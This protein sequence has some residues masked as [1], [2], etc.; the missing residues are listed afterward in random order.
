MDQGIKRDLEKLPRE[1]KTSPLYKRLANDAPRHYCFIH[2]GKKKPFEE[3]TLEKD[4]GVPGVKSLYNK[5]WTKWL[6][7]D[8]PFDGSAVRE[9]LTT[10]R[11][12]YE[13]NDKGKLEGIGVCVLVNGVQVRLARKEFNEYFECTSE[14]PEHLMEIDEVVEMIEPL[15]GFGGVMRKVV[16]KPGPSQRYVSSFNQYNP[17]A[18]VVCE[19]LFN[20][21][22][23]TNVVKYITRNMQALVYGVIKEEVFVD[24]GYHVAKNLMDWCRDKGRISKLIHP[25]LITLFCLRAQE[26]VASFKPEW[27]FYFGVQG[28]EGGDRLRAWVEEREPKRT[29]FSQGLEEGARKGSTSNT[30]DGEFNQGGP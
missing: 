20:K 29:R 1:V 7:M 14:R 5:G 24:L 6:E 16:L 21:V 19:V 12:M 15:K 3:K 23:S 17:E 4:L 8:A 2:L 30:A 9:F 26:S 28:A 11:P 13:E 22:Y 25:K 27:K 18:K 10:M